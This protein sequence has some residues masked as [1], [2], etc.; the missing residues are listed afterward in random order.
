MAHGTCASPFLTC[1]AP[2][3]VALANLAHRQQRWHIFFQ[4]LSLQSRLANTMPSGGP[5]RPSTSS[6]DGAAAASSTS[7]H[8]AFAAVDSMVSKQ[9]HGSDNTASWQ[10]FQNESKTRGTTVSTGAAPI[11]PI[12]R[13]DRLGTGMQSRD[14]EKRHE[15]QIRRQA[16]QAPVGSGYTAFKRKI[17][18]EAV[19]SAK[20]AKLVADRVR[21]DDKRYYIASETFE[22]WKEDY[23]FTTRDRG[24]GYYWDGMDS[25][26]K[27]LGLSSGDPS[28]SVVAEMKEK[29]ED[30]SGDGAD[31]SPEDDIAATKKK[32]KKKKKSKSKDADGTAHVEEDS[33]NPMDQIAAAIQRRNQ[34]MMHP[35][36]SAGRA[37]AA[38]GV[39]DA[40]AAAADAIG[41]TGSGLPLQVNALAAK[42]WE[43]AKDPSSGKEYYFNRSS[44][45]R[46]WDNPLL[47]KKLTPAGEVA[48]P[49]EK[50]EVLPAG[51]A[52][53]QDASIG[54]TYYYHAASGK[55]QWTKPDL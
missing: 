33:N 32:R 1:F 46:S 25:L 44:G 52:A 47:E 3:P 30:V 53:T 29:A 22:G 27:Q 4:E 17:D 37:A 51:W 36:G 9:V 55:T 5:Q 28:S 54:K 11:L 40:G 41:L 42:G 2:I 20:R 7:S 8:A 19:A 26:K 15:N 45:E 48:K 10:S 35:P 21:P 6:G 31:A 18:Q 38:A 12:K 39:A 34:A 14:D 23:V 50:D 16:G 24:T 49:S 43:K 13:A